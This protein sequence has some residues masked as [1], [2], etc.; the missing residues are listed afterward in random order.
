MFES[1]SIFLSFTI[2][3]TRTNIYG[4]S[5]VIFVIFVLALI[6]CNGLDKQ[7]RISVTIMSEKLTGEQS[8]GKMYVMRYYAKNSMVLYLSVS[9]VLRYI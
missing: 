9:F 3:V 1:V 6:T 2:L 7:N 5:F 8:N 4:A